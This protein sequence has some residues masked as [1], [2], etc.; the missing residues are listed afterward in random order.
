MRV[1]GEE[2][3]ASCVCPLEGK[4]SQYPCESGRQDMSNMWFPG[5][6]NMRQPYK[7]IVLK[8]WLVL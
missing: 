1:S 5:Q 2:I 3:G 7:L 8:E 4:P 6:A